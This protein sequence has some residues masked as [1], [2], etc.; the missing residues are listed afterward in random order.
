MRHHRP[1][2]ARENAMTD[3]NTDN[4]YAPPVPVE[5]ET[6][7]VVETNPS[8]LC[9]ILLALLLVWAVPMFLYCL[10]IPFAFP[11]EL[12]V[13]AFVITYP[14]VVAYIGMMFHKL[15]AFVLCAI[16]AFLWVAQPFLTESTPGEGPPFEGLYV[17]MEFAIALYGVPVL[18]L[19]LILLALTMKRKLHKHQVPLPLQGDGDF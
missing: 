1:V 6:P 10:I 11:S 12:I 14:F 19:S 18:V 4:P 7:Y 5:E 17:L 3:D 13:L 2:R 8:T 16:Y 9:F 15:W